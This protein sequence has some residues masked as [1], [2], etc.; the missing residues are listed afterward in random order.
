MRFNLNRAAS[1]A[2]MQEPV[3][4]SVKFL[5]AKA[6]F[7]SNFLQQTGENVSRTRCCDAG[8]RTIKGC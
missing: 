5:A 4:D 1:V 3:Q 2:A 6:N 8:F 7:R